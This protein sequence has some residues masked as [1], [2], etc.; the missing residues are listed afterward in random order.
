MYELYD[1]MPISVIVLE[2]N[3][4]RIKYTNNKFKNMFTSNKDAMGSTLEEIDKF[5]SCTIMK[6]L[7]NKC[8]KKIKKINLLENKFFDV[9]VDLKE[10][11]TILYIYEVT[12]YIESEGKLKEDRDKFL[13]IWS[14]M[15]T[16]CDI[17]EKLRLREKEYLVHLKNVVNNLSEG[18]IVL[19]EYGEVEFFNK[20]ALKITGLTSKGVYDYKDIVKDLNVYELDLASCNIDLEQLYK[21]YL[22]NKQTIKDKIIKIDRSKFIKYVE[23][24]CTPVKDKMDRIINSIITIKDI[25][26]VIEHKIELEIKNEELEKFTRMKDDYFN[27]ISHELRTPL[28]IIHSSLQLAKDVYTD[29][30]TDN[31]DKILFKITQNSRRLLKL[32]NNV[33]DISKAEAGFL[34]LNYKPCD[35][36]SI[37]ENLTSSANLY[38][39]SK[40]IE[41]LFDTNEEENL[42]LLDRDKYEKIVLNLLSNAIKF[43]P[44]NKNILV[45]TVIEEHYFELRVKDEGIGIPKD[46]VDKVFDRFTQVDNP[47]SK[48][49]DGTGLGL[50]LVKKLV[51]LMAGTIR[52]DSEEG[53]GTEFIVRLP[54]NKTYKEDIEDDSCQHELNNNKVIIEFSDV[55]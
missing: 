50:S 16:K 42:V 5:K 37:T 6:A 27:I 12:E 7:K 10:E 32:I 9:M 25:T 43:T 33:L 20:A 8:S 17:I 38:A 13:S 34:H 28:T 31:I 48:H 24:S 26:D 4:F 3:S 46:K 15:K 22:C 36:V 53:K 40:S 21:D 39:K 49:S 2:N 45:T 55:G 47:L 30:I 44:N 11:I 41:L 51:E 54:K 19:D 29:E 52:V 1:D 14:E 35:V 23:V 18:L